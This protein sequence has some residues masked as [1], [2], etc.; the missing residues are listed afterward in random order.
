M[1]SEFSLEYCEGI[2]MGVIWVGLLIT[3]ML[4]L[5]KDQRD[6]LTEAF[7]FKHLKY[8][9]ENTDAIEVVY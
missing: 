7:K 1:V 5:L 2:G 9:G 8:T 6:L 3:S 4:H